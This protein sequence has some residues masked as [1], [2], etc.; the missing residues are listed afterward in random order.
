MVMGM[1]SH[2]KGHGYEIRHCI[3][4]G[5]FSHVF[6]VELYSLF[7]KTENKQKEARL[8]Q[9]FFLKKASFCWVRFDLNRPPYRSGTRGPKGL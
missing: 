2:S 1:D 8:V 4:D 6:L 5:Y 9:F 7:E 3:L